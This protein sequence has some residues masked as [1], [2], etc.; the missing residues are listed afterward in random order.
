MCY[1]MKFSS[2]EQWMRLALSLEKAKK[3]LA[4][5]RTQRTVLLQLYGQK[6]V[7]H[8]IP[9]SSPST[10]PTHRRNFPNTIQYKPEHHKSGS[11]DT[12]FRIRKFDFQTMII[13]LSVLHSKRREYRHLPY[14]GP[15]QVLL[16]S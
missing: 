15:C 5:P 1:I 9:I 10:S 13:N 11:N 8:S 12:V 7:C 14:W 2:S 6:R 4:H 16:K 3:Y